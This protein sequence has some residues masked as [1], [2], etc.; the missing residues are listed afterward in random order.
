MADFI[1]TFGANHTDAAGGSLGRNFVRINQ[2]YAPQ[3]A[4]DLMFQARGNSWS[5][6]YESEEEAGVDQFDLKEVSLDQIKITKTTPIEA[7]P[8]T[9]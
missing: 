5:M 7:T 6:C 8:D 3:E 9:P 1:F 4:R 2:A